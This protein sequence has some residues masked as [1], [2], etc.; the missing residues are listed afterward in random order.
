MICILFYL[1]LCKS[2]FKKMEQLVTLLEEEMLL[3]KNL[4]SVN[5]HNIEKQSNAAANNVH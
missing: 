4:Y 3:E 1:E 2:A 5:H